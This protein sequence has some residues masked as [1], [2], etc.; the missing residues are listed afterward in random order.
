MSDQ[1][2]PKYPETTG[3]S[4]LASDE[5]QEANRRLREQELQQIIEGPSPM[6]HW[7]RAREELDQLRNEPGSDEEEWMFG[8]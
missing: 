2:G 4:P 3:I 7:R 1:E 8:R 6:E 5:E